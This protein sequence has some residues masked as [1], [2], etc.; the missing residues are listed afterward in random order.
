MLGDRI[1]PESSNEAPRK[2]LRVRRRLQRWGRRGVIILLV[3]GMM[4]LSP[5]GLQFVVA[6][7]Q[8]AT[9]EEALASFDRFMELV[10]ELRAQ[11]DATQF[12]V[13]ELA[14]ELAFEEPE[15][16]VQWV[17][18]HIAFEQYAGLLRG[19]RGTLMSRSGNALDQATLLARLLKDAGYDARIARGTLSR[20]ESERLLQQMLAPRPAPPPLGDLVEIERLLRRLGDIA[21]VSSEEL[22]P[23][24]G[25]SLHPRAITSTDLYR[26]AQRDTEF[27][28][29][30]LADAGV[31]LGDP[32]ATAGLIEEA[33]D[34][35][36]VEYSLDGSVWHQAHPSFKTGDPP[37]V[38]ASE[39][40]EESIP[41]ALQHRFRFEVVIEQKVGDKLETQPL[42]SPWE[43]PVANLVGV[44]LSYT[45]FPD[46]ITGTEDLRDLGA[47]LDNSN[48]YMPFF[49]GRL[50]T[51]GSFFDLNGNAVPPDAASSPYAGVFQTVGNKLES[52]IG[53]LAGL[54]VANEDETSGDEVLLTGL[55]LEFTLIGPGG[56]ETTYRR[57]VIDRITPTARA[58]G[59]LEL[60]PATPTEVAEALTANYT[61]MLAPG[62]YAEGFVADRFMA[63]LDDL[64]PFFELS[65]RQTYGVAGADPLPSEAFSGNDP[66]WLG[67]LK[68]FTIFDQGASLSA[69]SYRP[70]PA[71]VIQRQT[72]PVEGT[73]EASVD[74]VTNPR[75]AFQLGSDGIMPDARAALAAGVWETTTEGVVLAANMPELGRFG[76]ADVFRGVAPAEVA[77]LT[78]GDV[79]R[80]G[81]LELPVQAL[82]ELANDLTQGYTVLLPPVPSTEQNFAWWRIDTT[83]GETL[84]RLATGEGGE[85]VEYLILVE[86]AIIAGEVCMLTAEADSGGLSGEDFRVCGLTITGF[87][88]AGLIAALMA[89]GG[90]GVLLVLAI[91][92]LLGAI[93]TGDW[94]NTD[95]E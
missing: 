32:A 58:A 28:L 25:L 7:A 41:A 66:S 93:G 57:T 83:T 13:S 10:Q 60:A 81:Q 51:G 65:L 40:F 48:F 47:A 19:A 11:I 37:E 46:G 5:G 3:L 52:A 78:P 4:L 92:L 56:Q 88:G 61:W 53:G 34:Y 42:I 73:V 94:L 49:N 27:L 22:E 18:E 68:L 95:W 86:V 75:R 87:G 74:V 80:L 1:G 50:A 77:V 91:G 67:H 85:F 33:R 72:L 23:L 30:T 29:T 69:L 89:G 9:Y 16:I 8:P 12:D 31:G 62:N 6:Q 82:T 84:G 63:R 24:I 2:S 44:P 45:N 15:T 36:W 64:R 54:G 17:H 38:E 43:R 20:G 55:W 70:R 71:L 39:V 59:S 14:F 35:F 79:E 21:G 76:A 26:A 90:L